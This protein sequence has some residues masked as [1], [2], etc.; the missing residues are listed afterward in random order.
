MPAPS[1][2]P[3]VVRRPL[4]RRQL[5]RCLLALLPHRR[6]PPEYLLPQ[7]GNDIP[8]SMAR[9]PV[10]IPGSRFCADMQR[11]ARLRRSP[12]P[13]NSARTWLSPSS[14]PSLQCLFPLLTPSR[15]R[16]R[17]LPDRSWKACLLV[18]LDRYS[19]PS[20]AAPSPH[21]PRTSS[22]KSGASGASCTFFFRLPPQC[23]RKPIQPPHALIH[24]AR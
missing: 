21:S 24:L 23:R 13:Q 12:R 10:H 18:P 14:P 22:G 8:R 19:L 2:P 15:T 9:F 3:R 20:S 1:P 5:Q 17:V 11:H 7:N 16:S 6:T 4:H